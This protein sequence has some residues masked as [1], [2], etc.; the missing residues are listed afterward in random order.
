[1]EHNEMINYVEGKI[2]TFE[3]YIEL[4]GGENMS[5][6]LNEYNYLMLFLS[7][8]QMRVNKISEAY[9]LTGGYIDEE[10][11]QLLQVRQYIYNWVDVLKTLW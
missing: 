11:T 4:F 2:G 5:E 9:M 10:D 7:S 1:M 3:H 6:E 8:T